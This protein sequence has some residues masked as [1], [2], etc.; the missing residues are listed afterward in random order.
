MNTAKPPNIHAIVREAQS[1]SPDIQIEFL[2]DACGDDYLLF[3]DA[4]DVLH[5]GSGSE[6]DDTSSID[7]ETPEHEKLIGSRIGQYRIVGTLGSGGMGRVLLAERADRQF[8]QRVAIKL[9]RGDLLS[10]HVQVR[11][12]IERQI[13]ATLQHPNIAKLLD[14][15]THSG[16][17]YIVME[18]IEGKPIDTYCNDKRL[19]IRERLN[20]FKQVCSAV[21]YAH[22]NLIVHRDLKP[23]NILVTADG[24]PKLL[25]F[26][27]ARMLDSR[28]LT[29]T[30]A[31]T[32]FDSRLLTPDHASPE[33]L[34]GDPVT[35]ASD[36]Y[37]L[38][39]LLYELLTGRKPFAVRAERLAD[40][41]RAICSDPPAPLTLGLTGSSR[42]P[43]EFCAQICNERGTTPARLRKELEGDLEAIVAMAL[44]KEPE[45]RYSS[46]EQFSA[47]VDRLLTGM[48]ILARRD[49]LT[50]RATKFVKRHSI[51]VA[52]STTAIAALAAFA[53]LMS[54]QAQRIATESKNAEQISSFLIGIFEQAD[55]DRSRGRQI[56]AK[57]LLD[58]GA[59]RIQNELHKD[60]AVRARLLATLGTVYRELGSY[61]EAERALELSIA[62]RSDASI[63][64]D[65]ELADSQQ[66]L[67][68]TLIDNN[69]TEEAEPL[70]QSV[71]AIAR[72]EYGKSSTPTANALH[73]MAR[74]RH[75]QQR[76]DDSAALYAD[77]VRML[78][79]QS[80]IDYGQ[81]V[82]SL[83]D[84]AVLLVYRK[85]AAQS[86]AI[87]RKALAT[88]S[89]RL[90]QDHPL[91]IESNHGLAVALA[92]QGRFDE[93]RPLF[94]KS[95]QLSERVF[96]EDHPQTASALANYGNFL[97][98]AGHAEDA[99]HVLRRTVMMQAKI[100][101]DNAVRTAYA[102]VSLAF[103]LLE[104]SRTLEAKQYFDDALRTY[105]HELPADHLY[106]A[107]AL[108][109]KGR[110]LL[111]IENP[112]EASEA[113]EQAARIVK[114]H[115]PTTNGAVATVTSA[116]GAVLLAQNRLKEAEPLLRDAYP[117]LLATRGAPDAY[118]KQVHEW[119]TQLYSRLGRDDQAQAYFAS[120]PPK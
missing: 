23:S 104:T 94:E 112:S 77:C 39:V 2:R 74:L 16:M 22:Q 4:L 89:A 51:G 49:T 15:G 12:K 67:A 58:A 106:V 25:D 101:G 54:L 53:I 41:E 82:S 85:D 90:G 75:R 17:P 105:A 71:L 120:L 116:Q 8:E 36:T 46:V 30:L 73:T 92:G 43:A 86:E 10:K 99:E 117:I 52:M 31:V 33:Q 81:L 118:T 68:D 21:F 107:S 97:R 45:R 111:A 59:K 5:S 109:G 80:D 1:L 62:L 26:G 47:D 28:R 24:V 44:R 6:V 13:L 76:L 14:G 113:L 50:Y 95:L 103:L 18:Y 91:V 70:V 78:E 87:Y 114:R 37:V 100:S 19:S 93:A 98:T 57:E 27:I 38:G 55:P 115:Y 96:G 64:R 72:K 88:G 34:R 48:P 83:N 60:P 69:K 79:L 11:L 40:L 29:H 108:V 61:D 63:R 32:H 102:K 110:S 35:T 42:L 65:V 84:W 7:F 9:V 66:R 119:I 3:S 56:T 20:L